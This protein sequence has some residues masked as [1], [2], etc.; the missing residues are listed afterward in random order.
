MR[1]ELDD[2]L[3][4]NK[5]SRPDPEY[6]GGDDTHYPFQ[7]NAVPKIWAQLPGTHSPDCGR[8]AH[9]VEGRLGSP[10][11]QRPNQLVGY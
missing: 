3:P 9:W 8:G 11:A 4:P 2:E 7:I 10:L 1:L 6:P 5:P